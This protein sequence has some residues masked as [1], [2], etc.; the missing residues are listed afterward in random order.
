MI[1]LRTPVNSLPKDGP[2]QPTQED[3]LKVR[4]VH[5]VIIEHL[6]AD[7][8]RHPVLWLLQAGYSSSIPFQVPLVNYFCSLVLWSP[9]VAIEGN[10]NIP[11]PGFLDFTGK[12]KWLVAYSSATIGLFN[13]FSY[14]GCLGRVQGQVPRGGEGGLRNQTHWRT[15]P[16]YITL[17][18]DDAPTLDLEGI[19]R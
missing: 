6:I 7:T 5:S 16:S 13:L 15:S 17:Q 10:I 2:V 8:P 12:A 14:Q 11:R 19:E 3:K 9:P 1:P 18:Y 4:P